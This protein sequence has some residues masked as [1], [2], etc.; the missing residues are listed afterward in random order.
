[1]GPLMFLPAI[2]QMVPALI[3]AFGKN[4]ERA[5]QNAALAKTVVDTFTAAVPGAVNEL[6]AI[7]KAEADPVVR[8]E[9]AK[10]VLAQPDVVDMLNR[11]GPTFDRLHKIDLEQRAADVTG[12]D[13]AAARAQIDKTDL[14]PLLARANVL[15]V[16]A[17]LLLGM[18]ALGLQVWLS[19]SHE[20]SAWLIALLG[21]L[22]GTAFGGY[23]AIIAYRFDGTPS[24]NATKAINEQLAKI[25]REPKP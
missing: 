23:Q 3:G 9:A 4:S 1:M 19:E 5:Q 6:D 2:L 20:P 15:I 16:G 24:S 13:A 7:R 22:L 17:V 25:G 11:L 21:P 18:A 10:A 8:E 14:A 12:R